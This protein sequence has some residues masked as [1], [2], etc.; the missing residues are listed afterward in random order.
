MRLWERLLQAWESELRKASED[1]LSITFLT[2]ASV[3][4][5]AV[6]SL[7]ILASRSCTTREAIETRLVR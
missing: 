3:M 5:N 7:H 4:T 6:Q 2:M 1:R